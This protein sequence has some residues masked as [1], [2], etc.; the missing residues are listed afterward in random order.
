MA[1]IKPEFNGAL[2]DHTKQSAEITLKN[3]TKLKIIS[4]N[5][6]EQCKPYNNAWKATEST[7]EYHAR[8][9]LLVKGYKKDIT[10]G[11]GI[12]ALQE[13]PRT[14]EDLEYFKQQMNLGENW[15]IKIQDNGRGQPMVM[16]YN[17]DEV[18]EGLQNQ[19]PD[20]NGAAQTIRFNING[21]KLDLINVHAGFGNK[22]TTQQMK[23]LMLERNGVTKVRFGDHNGNADKF[24]D[25]K[26]HPGRDSTSIS[27]GGK[28]ASRFELE[29]KKYDG[30][31]CSNNA[32]KIRTF[33]SESFQIHTD[34]HGLQTS[35]LIPSSALRKSKPLPPIPKQKPFIPA[36]DQAFLINEAILPENLGMH[37]ADIGTDP[38]TQAIRDNIIARQMHMFQAKTAEMDVDNQYKIKGMPA[39]EFKELLKTPEVRQLLDAGLEDSGFIRKLNEIEV[40]GYKNVHHQFQEKFKT[41]EWDGEPDQPKQRLQKINNSDNKTI[42]TLKEKTIDSPSTITLADGSKQSISSYR[43]VNF[44]TS[45]KQG[46]SGPMHV[47]LAVKDTN[48]RN[49]AESKA[50]Y[51][52]AHYDREGKLNEVSAPQPIKFTGKG[53]DAVGYIERDGEIYTLPVTKEKYREMMQEVALNKGASIDISQKTPPAEVK[54]LIAIPRNAI[55]A[56]KQIGQNIEQRKAP[57]NKHH[58]KPMAQNNKKAGGGHQI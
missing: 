4:H 37:D 44:P 45:L 8:L 15:G 41:M 53:D 22:T 46:A 38:I 13:C 33:P 19:A 20:L 3:G 39:L 36:K 11:A 17:K 6:L 47:S 52:T 34:I 35:R 5:M 12:I 23:D 49:I 54:D 9:D 32:V 48:G 10:E 31:A 42:C 7:E 30:F 26:T 18:G 21:E 56:A 16:M 50:V 1:K 51:F 57:P 27:H 55:N 58:N 24:P 14:P 40:S 2:S 29:H 43:T 25:L 28:S